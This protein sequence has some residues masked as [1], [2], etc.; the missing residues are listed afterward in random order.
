MTNLQ[1]WLD[2][3]SENYLTINDVISLE[4]E[5][6]I[7]VLCIDRNFYDLLPVYY[8]IIDFVFV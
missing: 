1:D 7:K 3:N 2:M 8:I 6:V 4:N 5:Q